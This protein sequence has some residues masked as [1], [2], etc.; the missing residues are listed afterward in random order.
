MHSFLRLRVR[1][2]LL[3]LSAL[4]A[5]PAPVLSACSVAKLAELPVTMIGYRPLVDVKINGA[6]ARLV[7]DSGAFYSMLTKP[8]A[9]QFNLPLRDAPI[10]RVTGIGGA[11]TTVSMTTVKKLGISGTV[12]PNIQFLVGGSEAEAGSVGILG[13]NILGF[14]DTEY[15]FANGVIR[16]MRPSSDCHKVS[17]AYWA[18]D[19]AVAMV[20]IESI[21]DARYHT[22]G[23]AQVNGVKIRVMFDS[24]AGVSMLTLGAAKRAGIHMDD[25][26]VVRAGAGH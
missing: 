18:G 22:I 14:V 9:A 12:I 15:D 1:S 3:V 7:A 11:G 21:A 5:G 25:P 26:G 2:L 19:Q 4:F 17:L 8:T 13:Q 20:E 23:T 24:G 16:L 10:N 6:D